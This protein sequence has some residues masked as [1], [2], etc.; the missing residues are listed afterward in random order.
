MNIKHENVPGQL[1]ELTIEIQKEDYAENVDKALKK[2]RREI[3]VPGFRKGNA[4]MGIVQKMYGKNILVMEIDKLVNE[5]IEKFFKDNDIKFIFEPMPV[6]GKSQV[7]FDNP[8]NFSFVY[9]YVVRPEVN[10]D[11]SAM[12]AVTDFTVI[13][14][15]EEITTQIDQ[16]RERHGKY[17][18]P[19]TIEA[20]DSVS[21][22]YGGEKEAFFFIRDLKDDAR[23]EFIGKKKEDTLTMA[24]RKAFTADPFFA[25]A[26]DLKVDELKDDDPYTYDL[27]IKRIGRINPAELNEDFFKAAY[28]DGSVTDEAT[29]RE[30]EK[31]K[32]AAQYK[33]DTDRMFMDRAISTLLDNVNVEL[34]DD[35]M[36]RYILAVQKDMT[37]EALDKEFERYKNSFKWQIIENTLV[38]GEDV[39]VTRADIEEY[40]RNYFIQNYFANFNAE[41]VKDQVDKIV[42]DSMKNQEYVKNAYDLLYDQKLVA[43]MRKKM[44]INHK[45]GDFKAFVDEI[46]SERKDEK[47]AE[48]ASAEEKPKKTTKRKTTAKKAETEEPAAEA[49]PAEEKPKKTRAKSTKA[50]TEKE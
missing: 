37:E 4:P 17:E 47:P 44:N 26:F 29:M 19:D 2:Q 3:A 11:L 14:S 30:T 22:S 39:N 5:Q 46:S 33:P 21:V 15:E 7:D 38:E 35:F 48:E 43:L 50:K 31:Q 6:E 41:S 8:D 23:K 34:P 36:R 28:P 9:E 20:N 16:L 27:T 24:M 40:F 13:P 42:A 18:M 49:A 45:E 32:I 12:P 1:Q 25:R 10:I